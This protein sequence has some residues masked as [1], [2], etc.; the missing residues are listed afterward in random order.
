MMYY[1]S[2]QKGYP[3]LNI[4]HRDSASINISIEN[5]DGPNENRCFPVSYTTETDSNFNNPAPLLWLQPPKKPLN[6]PYNHYSIMSLPYREDG[7]IIFNIQQTGK[8]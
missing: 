6:H 5:L 8:S 7:W 4:L 2:K 3:V 1:W